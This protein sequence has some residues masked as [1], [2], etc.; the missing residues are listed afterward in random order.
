M[1]S[2]SSSPS[3]ATASN[4]DLVVRFNGV[5]PDAGETPAAGSDATANTSISILYS[6]F[7]LLVDAGPG[8][9]AS[10]E[11]APSS[12]ASGGLA[13]RKTPDAILVTSSK[14]GHTSDLAR[15]GSA[16]PIYCTATC[17]D[18]VSKETQIPRQ[19]FTEVSPGQSFQ[20]GPFLVMPIAAENAAEGP[21]APGSLVYVIRAGDRKIIAGWDFL[22]L[23]GADPGI[24]WNPDLAVLGTETYNSHPST[25]MI[26]VTEAYDIIRRWNAKDCYIVH[27]SGEK[28]REDARNQWHRGPDKPLPPDELQAVIDEHLRA[29]GQGGKFKIRVARQG[30]VWRPA[31]AITAAGREDEEK[32]DEGPVG[33]KI[34]VEATEKYVFAIEKLA[35]TAGGGDGSGS[36]VSFTLEDSINRLTAEFVNPRRQGN[37]LHADAMK[38]MMMKGPELH[39]EILPGDSA[40]VRV[41]ITKGKKEVFAGDIPV[42]ERDARR[43]SKY[44]AEN[45]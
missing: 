13:G 11:K 17:A 29:S 33:P 25:G 3:A 34:E 1:A 30:M 6:N 14:P 21:G 32:G 8:V 23:V 16:P 35:A 12:S 18:Q 5:L 43:L 22:R 9:A 10:L 44:L 19:Q 31:T 26:S 45:F 20:V 39:L 42:S 4:N 24:T 36:R 7:H 2:P 40:L 28:D 41:N 15:V 37:S 27:Y 38:S